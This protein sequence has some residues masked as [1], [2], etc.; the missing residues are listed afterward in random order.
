MPD[1]TSTQPQAFNCEGGLVLNR[2]TFLMQPGEALTLQNFE[3]DVSGG[4]RRIS[5]YKKYINQ[6]VP[7]TSSGTSKV[8]MCATFNN[9]IIAAREEK[10]FTTASTE[11][12]ANIAAA[13]AM[14]GSGT[15]TVDS[16]SGFSSTGTIQINNEAFAFTGKTATTFTGVTRAQSNA[17]GDS[18]TAAQHLI[19]DV[20]SENFTSKI[21]TRTSSGIYTYERYN[22]DGNDKFIM[23]SGANL[24]PVICNASLS[25][26]LVDSTT[27]GATGAA[28]ILTTAI[29]ASDTLN[30]SGGDDIIYV[31]DTS[32]FNSSGK[33]II[34]TEEFAYAGKTA[35][36]FTGVNRAQSS[37]IAA[38]HEA[39][40]NV[41][42]AFPPAVRGAQFVTAFKD[43]MF[44]AGMSATPQEVVFSM[45]GEEA[46]F[47]VALGAGSFRVDDTITGLKVFRDGLFIFCE[48][49][50]FKLSGTSFADFAVTPV[51]RNIGCVNGQTIQEFAGDLIFLGPD[52]LRTVAG[53]ARIGDVELGTISSPIQSIFNDNLQ[54][55]DEFVSL[56]IP[57]K[58]QY[59]LF[60][61]K[62][63]LAED[64]TKGI[65]CVLREGNRFEFSELKGIRPACTDSFV[66]TGDVIVLHG[67]YNL[68]YIYRQELGKGFDSVVTNLNGS[69]KT[70]TLLNGS[71]TA[72]AT[73]I[74]VDSTTASSP[75]LAFPDAVDGSDTGDNQGYLY[76]GD[77]QITYE[78][79][80][81]TSFTGCT[82]GANGTTAAAHADD[83]KVTYH[84]KTLTVRSTTG[85]SS[86]GT[87][88]VGS[89]QIT[90]TGVTSTTFANCTRGA[91]NTIPE[92]YLDGGKVEQF[93]AINGVYRSPDLTFNDA[94]VRKHFQR[95]LINYKPESTIDADLFLRYDFNDPDSVDPAAYPFDIS[96]IG[97]IY[98]TSKYADATYGGVSQPL[99]RQAVEGSGF[100][101][102]LKVA[103]GGV[104]SPYSLKGFQLE[105]QIGARR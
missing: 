21:T 74:T 94:G 20:V 100:A 101:V 78:G 8:L 30:A 26:S 22:F 46:N 10:I 2:S 17:D 35:T 23:A 6:V 44:Y 38:A 37:S 66:R 95:I 11:L 58:T 42:D 57:E 86:S 61:S 102:A 71:L 45:I 5:G 81:S 91:N 49:R 43:H 73:T 88:Y 56:V 65:T 87:L 27:D 77:E 82:R 97:A 72:T 14:T 83:K 70:Q 60:F 93:S 63:T 12:G 62:S 52:G 32:N 1:L 13:T 59:R 29:A 4:Y 64:N 104:S 54:D 53:T 84:S 75:N 90:Y 41:L 99:V 40:V 18:T 34:G 55:S 47:S 28:T 92:P 25:F 48:N 79:K 67:S 69:H 105:Y 3:P 68:G 85:F 9:N 80:T 19:D 16:T 15:I 51:T 76:I 36:T 39:N 103:D 33:L 50:I 89:E 7:I 31:Q 24:D 96:D 98:G